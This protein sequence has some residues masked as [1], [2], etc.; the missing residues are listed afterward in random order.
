MNRTELIE[1][2]AEKTGFARK[3]VEKTVKVLI[4]E[5]KPGIVRNVSAKIPIPVKN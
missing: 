3:D 2:I 4:G 1:A 5:V